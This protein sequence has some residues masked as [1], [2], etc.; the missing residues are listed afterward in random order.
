[1]SKEQESTVINEKDL[2]F[3]EAEFSGSN[4]PWTLQEL[5]R[6]LA[7]KKSSSQLAQAVK[8]YDP[9]CQYEIGDLIYKE[10]DEPLMVSSKGMQPF[11]GGIVLTV[12]NKI[13][14]E[15][16]NCEMIE[17]DYTGG[18][19][20][21]KHIDYMKKTKTQ[22]LLPSNQ[23]GKAGVPK[24]LKK[25]KDPR[26]EELP[27]TDKDLKK[28][29]KNLKSALLKSPKFL[30]WNDNWQHKEKLISIDDTKIKKI[31][32]HLAKTKSSAETQELI[33][34]IFD[35][36]EEELFP[37]NCLSL[38]YT[39]E[40][41]WKK[42]FVFV[43]PENWG[44]WI[45]KETLNSFLENLPLTATKAKPPS[46]DQEPE[47]LTKSAPEFPLKLYLGW[48]ELLSGGLKVPKSINRSLSQAREY[49]FADAES[50][51]VYTVYYYPSS[52]FFIGLKDYYERHNVPQGASLTLER[53]SPTHFRFWIK[54]SKKKI[55]VPKLAYDSKKDKFESSG[56][57]MFTFA[58]PNKIIHLQRETLNNLLDLYDQR[59]NLNLQKLLFIVYKTF[60][61][62]TDKP[63]L[64]YLRAYHIVDILKRTTEEDIEKTLLHADEFS[65]SEKKKG[66]YHYQEKVKIEEEK[67]A[68]APPEI[69][70]E[71]APEEAVEE[72][73]P[74]APM[75]GIAPPE[76]VEEREAVLRAEA[77]QEAQP[78]EIREPV[79]E[80]QPIPPKKEKEHKKKKPKARPEVE[81]AVRRR[82]T[83]RKI[84]EERIEQEE[85]E[86]EAL[87]AMKEKEKKEIEEIPA[88]A[89]P[90][91]T[92]KEYKTYVS[93]EP[94]FG[95]FAEKLKTALDKK[96]KKKEEEKK[97]K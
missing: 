10:Y 1:M 34:L 78:V 31:E 97:K 38:N 51:K 54:K 71:P 81:R 58:L 15:S 29:E 93:E 62:G 32:K 90:K 23:D 24:I 40:K 37:L 63:S 64:H 53:K 12:V 66:L 57:D 45:L 88:K 33:S 36:T 11:K 77:P 21:R 9:D 75:A 69:P 61:L 72:V 68:E 47:P 5:T 96:G 59:R 60:G 25:D 70:A 95:V 89:G 82:K 14:Y 2:E 83:E 41:K 39:L 50:D 8:I 22:V 85:S 92:K 44:K 43:S 35:L 87:I 18:G 42:T 48:R 55:T 91:E 6:K 16:F 7:Y 46:F 74:A 3:I 27:M 28:L 65:K 80:D 19:V 76:A 84:I 4:Q 94:V 20:F 73:P 86:H 52:H 13:P 56:E 49:S 30:S 26:H 79:T 67:E 17:V